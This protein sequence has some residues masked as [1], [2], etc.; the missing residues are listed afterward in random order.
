MLGDMG[1]EHLGGLTNRVYASQEQGEILK[2]GVELEPVAAQE[3]LAAFH[4]CQEISGTYAPA[5]LM[6]PA[7]GSYPI[8][9]SH[10]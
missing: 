6:P 7:F 9:P 4:K 3:R 5:G 10:F 2:L 1:Y 8:H